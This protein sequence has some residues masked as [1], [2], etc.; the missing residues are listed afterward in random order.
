MD[1]IVAPAWGIERFIFFSAGI[2]VPV[3]GQTPASSLAFFSGFKFSREKSSG[4]APS[5]RVS[6]GG[7]PVLPHLT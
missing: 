2:P 1:I 5:S 4:G 6:D 3:A 7:F